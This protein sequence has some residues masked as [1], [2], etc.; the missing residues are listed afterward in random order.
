MIYINDTLYTVS[1]NE[2]KSYD[3]QTFNVLGSVKLK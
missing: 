1:R 3:L 2:V